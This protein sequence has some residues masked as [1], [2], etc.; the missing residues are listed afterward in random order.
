M[1]DEDIFGLNLGSLMGKTMQRLSPSAMVKIVAISHEIKIE[2]HG[3]Q[4]ANIH[5]VCK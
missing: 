1:A 2:I 4:P 5:H 3:H